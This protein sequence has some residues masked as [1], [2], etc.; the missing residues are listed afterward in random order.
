MTQ[1][2]NAKFCIPK[3]IQFPTHHSKPTL[4]NNYLY[5]F[6]GLLIFYNDMAAFVC[7]EAFWYKVP[8]VSLLNTD[9]TIMFLRRYSNYFNA[10][11]T[12]L[13][14]AHTTPSLV[15]GCLHAS[16]RHRSISVLAFMSL[17]HQVA[18]VQPIRERRVDIGPT[19]VLSKVVNVIGDS[20][21]YCDAI[22]SLHVTGTEE[23]NKQICDVDGL[24]QDCSNSSVLRIE[25]LQFCTNTSL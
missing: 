10:V 18:R 6:K 17:C 25:V 12:H 22:S 20:C 2:L 1:W 9:D 4:P 21:N 7:E 14:L 19:V 5:Y 3:N 16:Q 23:E 13:T 24:V 15:S 8:E 11:V